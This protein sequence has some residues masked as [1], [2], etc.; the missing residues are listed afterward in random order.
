MLPSLETVITVLDYFRLGIDA[1]AALKHL[2]YGYKSDFAILPKVEAELPWV[3]D[4]THRLTTGLA[5]INL[6]NEIARREFLIAPVLFDLARFTE[7][8]VQSDFP[9][10]AGDHL[11]GTID[12]FLQAQHNFLIVEAKNADLQRGFT[13]LAAE[14]VALDQMTEAQVE[15]LYGAVS[16]GNV[17]QFGILDRTRK[18]V[19][20]DLTLY[21]VPG[22][23]ETLL[24]ILVG[25]LA[26][27]YGVPQ[28]SQTGEVI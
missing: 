28:T 15:N 17:W 27:T 20:Q 3:A 8:R 7:A 14:L 18:Q 6:T 4:L 11:R 21:T 9:L 25:I 2:N 1:A 19:T 24:Q 5:F 16:I 22:M 13:Q 26:P 23:L 12:Y 10:D